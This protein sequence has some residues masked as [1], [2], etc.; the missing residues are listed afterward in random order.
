MYTVSGIN[1][2]AFAHLLTAVIALIFAIGTIHD[3]VADFAVIDT[4]SIAA[5]V[6]IGV[7]L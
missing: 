4:L 1:G 2:F 7:A 5:S 3:I 6:L